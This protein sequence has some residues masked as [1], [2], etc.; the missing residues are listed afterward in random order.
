MKY[1]NDKVK[2]VLKLSESEK[3]YRLTRI[4]PS[5]NLAY[6][7]EQYWIVRWDL[8]GK[9]SHLQENIPHPC[10]HLVLERNN[11]RIIGAVTRKYAYSLRG[12]GKIVGVK[13]R[14]G[15]FYPFINSPVSSFTDDTINP[16]KVFGKQ[17]E[18]FIN[19]VLS[20]TEDATIVARVEKFLES[21]LPLHKDKNIEKVNQIIEKIGADRSITKVEDL[22][23]LYDIQKRNLQRLFKTYVG[24]GPKWVIK[25]FRLHE[26][27]EKMESGSVDWQQLILELGYYDQAHFI[28]DFKAIIGK[29][30]LVYMQGRGD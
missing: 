20:D 16:D 28:K 4:L 26:V 29:S 10:I 23:P 14:P 15:G 27:L 13:F 18:D 8:R 1:N 21:Y 25:K 11:S 7:V 12:L 9:K 5:E 6:Y 19:D 17:C 2:G 24:V 22:L 30:P 3:N